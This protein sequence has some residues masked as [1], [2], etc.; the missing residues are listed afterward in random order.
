MGR[1]LEGAEDDDGLVVEVGG[2]GLKVGDGLE[3][4]VDGGLCGGVVLGL[5]E[6]RETLVAEHV[7]GGVDG[8]DDAVGEE[9]DEVAGAGGEGELFVFGVG[10]EA[11][12]EA[13]GLDGADGGWLGRVGWLTATKRG[14]TEPAL[15]IW[16]VWLLSSQMAMSMV[17]YWESSLRSWSWSLSAA[18]MAA[19]E[20]CCGARE[21]RMPLTSAA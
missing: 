16:R 1:A 8:V 21:R 18:S 3:D 9:D 14:W 12:G 11:E 10:K 20:R 19:G 13:F 15:A 6:F 2:A 7:A 4:G 17:T 5:E